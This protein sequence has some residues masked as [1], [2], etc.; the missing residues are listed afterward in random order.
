MLKKLKMLLIVKH[1]MKFK[2]IVEISWLNLLCN[3]IFCPCNTI[4]LAQ[5]NI[6]EELH[7]KLSNTSTE[8]TEWFKV[9][10]LKMNQYVNT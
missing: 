3:F 5:I 2:I 9:N 10:G 6:N 7:V 8:L 4:D 1:S